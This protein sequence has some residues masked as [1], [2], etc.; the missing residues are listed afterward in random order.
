MPRDVLSAAVIT[1]L[2]PASVIVEAALAAKSGSVSSAATPAA[3]NCV[4]ASTP[5]SVW[6]STTRPSSFASV[7]VGSVSVCSAVPR[8][9]LSAAVITSL[10]PA[11]VIVEAALALKSGS[12]SSAVT[13]AAFNCVSAS[14]PPSVWKSTTRPSSFASVT[15]GSVSICTAVPRDVLSAAVITSLLPA[16]VMLDAALAV[17]AGS[18]S[19][20]TTPERAEPSP[21]NVTAPTLPVDITSPSTC[22]FSVPNADSND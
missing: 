19:L 14:T 1:S 7:T 4:S 20:V 2:L 17:N 18:I 9:V 3:S 21:L 22:S 12:V 15:V 10:L 8:D 13:P 16:D 5:P 11:S 6:K